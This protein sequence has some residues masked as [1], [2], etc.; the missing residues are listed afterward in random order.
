MAM[1]CVV[2][3]KFAEQK[4]MLAL[5]GCTRSIATERCKGNFWPPPRISGAKG[6]A[7]ARGYG[8]R[9][10]YIAGNFKTKR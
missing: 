4:Q 1:I 2:E 9:K 10:R 5:V 3:H 7:Y 6:P 8:D